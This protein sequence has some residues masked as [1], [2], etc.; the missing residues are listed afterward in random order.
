[1]VALQRHRQHGGAQDRAG[2]EHLPGLQ[3]GPPGRRPELRLRHPLPLPGPRG[4]LA[5]L[6]HPDQPRRRRDAPRDRAG[7]EGRPGQRHRHDRR[8]TWDP[9][10][11]R[12]LFT[13][14]S[15]T[16]ADLLG[17]ARFPVDGARRLRRAR[18]RRLRGHPGRLGREHLDRRGHRRRASQG[19]CHRRREGARTA[20]S[21]ATSRPRRATSPTASSRCCRSSTPRTS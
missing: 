18:P 10:A 17:H 12:L 14:E 5:G 8:L 4:R 1:M 19:A 15:A 6:H 9:W 20:T 3:E 7:D 11:Q 21:T 13:T 16:Q 2:Q